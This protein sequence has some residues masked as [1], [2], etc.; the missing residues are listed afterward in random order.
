MKAMKI[1]DDIHLLR[2]YRAGDKDAFE[3]VYR[4]YKDH[5]YDLFHRALRSADTAEELTQRTFVRLFTQLEHDEKER[6]SLGPLV[7]SIQQSVLK[8]WL[9]EKRKHEDIADG[10]AVFPET[11]ARPSD[12]EFQN[13][14]LRE[15]LSRAWDTLVPRRREAATMIHIEGLG[16]AETAK[17]LGITR[18]AA[19]DLVKRATMQLAG[20]LKQYKERTD[21]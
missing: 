12:A 8:D 20:K 11:H 3:E 2:R 5:V 17:R 19:Y 16:Y 6:K 18:A 7:L 10:L 1:F 15:Q 21:P 13:D 4:Q 9:R 14:E